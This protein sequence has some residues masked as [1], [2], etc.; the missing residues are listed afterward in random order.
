MEHVSELAVDGQKE[1]RLPGKWVF[2]KAAVGIGV[3]CS[4][5][6]SLALQP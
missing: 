4:D 6:C 3:E 5:K 1:A 2:L